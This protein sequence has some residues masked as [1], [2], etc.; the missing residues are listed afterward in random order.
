MK[1]RGVLR[2]ACLPAGRL[3]LRRVASGVGT[4]GPAGQ[5]C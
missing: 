5:L 1:K 2:L 3:S 4:S